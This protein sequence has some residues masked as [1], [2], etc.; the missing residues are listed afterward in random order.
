MKT[1]ID[2]SYHNKS[3]NF[4][5]VKNDGID[6]IIP[7]V[8]YRD[9]VDPKFFEYVN[10][11]KKVGIQILG[12][13]FFSYALNT[14]Q[15]KDEA[16]LCVETM[17]AV[18]L[19]DDI[20]VFYDFEYDTIKKAKEKNVILTAKD[21]NEHT[22]E[23]CM[24]I[25]RLG[26]KP[27][28]YTNLDYYKNWYDKSVLQIYPIWLADYKGD[29]DYKCIIQQYTNVGKINGIS[30]FVD[31]NR[32]YG[33]YFKTGEKNMKT[34]NKVVEL[35]RSWIGKNEKDGSHKEIIDIYNG[36]SGELPRGVKMHY[37]YAW[38]ACTW[39][40][41]AIKL[42][43]TDIMPIECSCGEL[44]KK[45]K[46][47]GIW[48]EDDSYVASPGDAILYD[49]EDNGIGDNTGWPDH[50]GI[51]ERVTNG[52]KNGRTYTVI[53]GNKDDAV[54]RRTIKVN[55]KYIRGFITPKYDKESNNKNEVSNP[56]KTK[57]TV[58]AWALNCREKPSISSRILCQFP[59]GTVLE[60][61]G[62]IEN[63]S[64]KRWVEVKVTKQNKTGWCSS[65]A[66]GSVYL[67]EG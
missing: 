31:M 16:K 28:I 6:F 47:M 54:G 66:N 17:E 5:L 30:T 65:E 67:K 21:C 42:G 46:K 20:F 64:G 4:E 33:E 18:G 8:G 14:D 9:K 10:G 25:V 43:Y 22:K 26:H 27:G 59:K 40:A 2:I 34:S 23:F 38:C 44:I 50:V 13:Y 1:G 32:Y 36:Y 29:A 37:E 48:V 35:A 12:V 7:R 41:I 24:E 45:A 57:W 62:N 15:V 60:G 61:T 53:E 58:T 11:A 52:A 51:I 63:V 39:S 19:G 55:G 3:I 56:N 49:W